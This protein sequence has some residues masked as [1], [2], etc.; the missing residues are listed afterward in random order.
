MT[1]AMIVGVSQCYRNY[2]C[3]CC[4]HYWRARDQTTLYSKLNFIVTI[5]I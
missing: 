2:S 3:A 1:N 4:I 5:K